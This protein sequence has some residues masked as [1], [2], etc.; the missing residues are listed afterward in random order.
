MDGF[1]ILFIYKMIS[2]LFRFQMI[3]YIN[4]RQVNNTFAWLSWSVALWKL[5]SDAYRLVLSSSDDVIDCFEIHRVFKRTTYMSATQKS[6]RLLIGFV[7]EN[8]LLGNVDI[9]MTIDCFRPLL[10]NKVPINYW[11]LSRGARYC[12]IYSS[13][14]R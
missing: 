7:R 10:W 5:I 8:R 1:S 4:F 13:F 2:A 9:V 12:S 3:K 6:I 11:N 14:I